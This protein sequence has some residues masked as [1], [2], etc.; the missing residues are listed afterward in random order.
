M[1][2]DCPICF[3]NKTLIK[4]HCGH[5]FCQ[6]CI[7]AWLPNLNFKNGSCPSCRQ[8]LTNANCHFHGLDVCSSTVAHSL[9][10]RS[11][12]SMVPKKMEVSPENVYSS[13]CSNLPTVDEYQAMKDEHR[14]RQVVIQ[15]EWS[16]LYP[17]K[18]YAT[19]SSPTRTE[20]NFVLGIF[21]NPL[22]E[23]NAVEMSM[24]CDDGNDH[25][26]QVIYS[27]NV[28]NPIH[29]L[30]KNILTETDG[31]RLS[32]DILIRPMHP[33]MNISIYDGKGLFHTEVFRI[34]VE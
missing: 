32:N 22:K 4:L 21:Y 9:D 3:E 2:G 33:G 20:K 13:L 24:R 19:R 10:M 27:S 12:W 29:T 6:D 7:E 23:K 1:S 34:T 25:V 14:G 5:V 11:Y 16:Q 26:F 18:L 30:L 17:T 8:D 31:V 28:Q 15:I